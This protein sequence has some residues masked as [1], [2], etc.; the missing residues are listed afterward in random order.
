MI[1]RFMLAD[2][3][4][5]RFLWVETLNTATYVKNRLS[6]KGLER[7][8]TPYEAFHDIKPSIEHLQP[9][10]RKCFVHIPLEQR[11]AG[12]KLMPRTKIGY[13]VKYNSATNKI[14]RI[15]ILFEYKDV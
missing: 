12:S 13:F 15:Y 2:T 8:T 5:S 6:Y 4:L 9:F 7:G 11:K 1:A 3:K 10:D 14:Y